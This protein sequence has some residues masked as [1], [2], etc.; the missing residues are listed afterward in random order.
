MFYSSFLH[1]QHHLSA[2]NTCQIHY[3]EYAKRKS[4]HTHTTKYKR[5]HTHMHI[6]KLLLGLLNN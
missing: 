1:S 4:K 6:R 5:S 3:K 2:R